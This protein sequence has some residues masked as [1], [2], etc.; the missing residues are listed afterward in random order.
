MAPEITQA[1]LMAA[2]GL[3]ENGQGAQEQEIA[4]PAAETAQAEAGTGAQEQEIADPA[5]ATADIET[6]GAEDGGDEGAPGRKAQSPEERRANAARRRQQEQ[7][8]AVDQAVNAAVKAEQEKNDAVMRQFFKDANLKNTFTGQLITTMEEFK[9]WKQQFDEA[10]VKKATRTGK[11]TAEDLDA[12]IS[13]HP[14]VQK[15][16]SVIEQAEAAQKQQQE[17][18]DRARIDGELAEISKLNPN[19]KGMADIL[20]LP[21]AE[22]FRGYIKKGHGLLDAF[23]LANFDALTTARAEAAKQQALNNTRGKEHLVSTGASRGPG[24]ASV[25]A[26]QMRYFRAMMPDKTDAQIQAFYNKHKPK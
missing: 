4:D 13:R 24:A 22:Q 6:E 17:A 11:M 2:F 16:Q 12:A 21:T 9:A 10:R 5:Q 26:D 18:A 20:K 15:A 23:R 19:I 14:V 8:A 7:Q 1:S 25:P 3:T